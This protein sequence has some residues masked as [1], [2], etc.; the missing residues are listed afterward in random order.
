MA[1]RKL[2]YKHNQLQ[3]LRGF[4]EAARLGN[5]SRAAE[6]LFLSQPSVSLQI[7]ALEDEL[8]AHLFERRGPKIKLTS[9]GELLYEMALPLVT[10]MEALKD[11]FHSR[12]DNVELGR[13]DIAAGG[14][15]L[16]YVLPPYVESFVETYPQVELKLHNVTGKRGLE[17]LRAGEADFA[18]GPLFEIPDD[19]SFH[20]FVSYEPMLITC[21]GHPLAE[22]KRVTLRDIS[23]YPLILPPRDQ[24]TWRVVDLVFADHQLSYNV[25]LEVGGWPVIKQY[26]SIGLGVSI[27][28]S[29][30]LRE[31]DKLEVRPVSQYFPK[32]TYGVVLPKG[33]SISRHAQHFIELLDPDTASEGI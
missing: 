7:R 6:S 29:I 22:K 1:T 5:I 28:M 17:R 27:V 26:V 14:S 23:Q 18:V 33:R 8:D 15:T 31:D 4:C 21:P 10:G 24:S 12:R 11:E 2:R 30:C 20:P 16:L 25:R 13:L 3:Q 19:L 9:E 32:R